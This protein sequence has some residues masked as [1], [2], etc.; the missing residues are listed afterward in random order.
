MRSLLFSDWGSRPTVHMSIYQMSFHHKLR[1]EYDHGWHMRANRGLWQRA[2]KKKQL[3]WG[4]L[5]LICKEAFHEAKIQWHWSSHECAQATCLFSPFKMSSVIEGFCYHR[6]AGLAPFLPFIPSFHSVFS[7][8][9]SVCL[10]IML[11]ILSSTTPILIHHFTQYSFF[12]CRS[13]GNIYTVCIYKLSET[14]LGCCLSASPVRWCFFALIRKADIS[15]RVWRKF[16]LYVF[17]RPWMW[18][19]NI[20]IGLWK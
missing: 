19:D 2:G 20:Y 16:V 1:S 13:Y 15:S 12:S 17:V 5:S 7:S 10:C 18:K 8:F 11:S 6:L 14:F 9:A 3:P 4:F